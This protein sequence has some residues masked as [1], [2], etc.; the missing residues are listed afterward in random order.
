MSTLKMKK[1]KKFLKSF[2]G[3]FIG[4]LEIICIVKVL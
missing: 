1:I 4:V 2:F 3:D